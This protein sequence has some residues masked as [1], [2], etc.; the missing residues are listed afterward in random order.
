M[1]LFITARKLVWLNA[2][3]YK[4]L[5]YTWPV[6]SVKIHSLV[7]YASSMPHCNSLSF[8][9]ISFSPRFSNARKAFHL[10]GHWFWWKN[11]LQKSLLYPDRVST[12]WRKTSPIHFYVLYPVHLPCRNTTMMEFS[13]GKKSKIVFISCNKLLFVGM[14]GRRKIIGIKL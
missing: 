3:A 14:D 4:C 8:L 9:R 11:S 6:Y 13:R 10:A 12:L 7:L 1:V 5:G 2:V